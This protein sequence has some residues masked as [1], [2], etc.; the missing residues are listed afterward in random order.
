MKEGQKSIHDAD[1]IRFMAEVIG[2]GQW[3]LGVMKN[4]LSLDLTKVPR[5]YRE[6]N[7][8]SADRNMT[9]LKDKVAEW[10]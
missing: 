7:N 2:A 10:E 5:K 3:Q 4:G 9:V 8:A 1:S 6:K